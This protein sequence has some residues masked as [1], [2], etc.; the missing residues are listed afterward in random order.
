[1]LPTKPIRP[2][3]IRGGVTQRGSL[4]RTPGSTTCWRSTCTTAESKAAPRRTSNAAP[5]Y[6]P[7]P[8][9]FWPSCHCVPLSFGAATPLG[10]VC[11]ESAAVLFR[12]GISP[13][14]PRVRRK[15]LSTS[16][17]LV[18]IVVGVSVVTG[19][20]SFVTS[21]RYRASLPQA[22]HPLRVVGAVEGRIA[23]PV[24]TLTLAPFD[25]LRQVQPAE[26]KVAP[27]AFHMVAPTCVQWK[28]AKV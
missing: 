16:V 26:L 3:N 8:L 14:Y 27:G 5:S 20:R 18:V 12:T 28:R 1:M 9:T 19:C 6:Y 11:L 15:G 25:P 23:R 13:D 17:S 21:S 7:L 24:P 2:Q 22:R 10:A 4:H